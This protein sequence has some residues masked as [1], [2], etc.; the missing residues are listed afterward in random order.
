M[1]KKLV[2][3]DKDGFEKGMWTV[4]TSANG[5]QWWAVFTG[6]KLETGIIIE[7]F[8]RIGYKKFRPKEL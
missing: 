6:V 1:K 8:K 4:S 3:V 7:A 2:R 5:N